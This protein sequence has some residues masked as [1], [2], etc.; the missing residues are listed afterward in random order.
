MEVQWENIKKCVLD[1]MS[2]LG[3]KEDRT[4]RKPR[5]TQKL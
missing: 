4:A 1:N 3:E 5:N 2:G